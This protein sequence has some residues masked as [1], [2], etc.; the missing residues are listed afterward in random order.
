MNGGDG[1][2][3]LTGGLGAD[4]QTG[5]DKADAFVFLALTDSTKKASGRDSILDFDRAEGDKIDLSAI[6][7]RTGD[8]SAT[9]A[10]KFIGKKGFDDVDGKKGE[11]RSVEKHGDS[12]IQGDVN[13]DDKADFSILVDGVSKLKHTDFDL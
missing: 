12:L 1:A 10:F 11:L 9:S 13:G 7:A 8:G 5:G 4:L 6:D 2:D 3:R